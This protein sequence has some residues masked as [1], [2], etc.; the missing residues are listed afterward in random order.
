MCN[1]IVLNT[2]KYYLTYQNPCFRIWSPRP[3]NIPG[4]GGGSYLRIHRNSPSLPADLKHRQPRSDKTPS[5]RTSEH[6]DRDSRVSPTAMA[7][8]VPVLIHTL[9]LPARRRP[10]WL[11]AKEGPSGVLHVSL[12]FHGSWRRG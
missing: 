1:F 3:S 10:L 8:T 9:L 2:T 4:Q 11:R 6:P 12:G 7:E 5:A